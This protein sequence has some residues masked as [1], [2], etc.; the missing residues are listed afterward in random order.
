MSDTDDPSTLWFAVGVLKDAAQAILS[1][2]MYDAM[3]IVTREL[4]KVVPCPED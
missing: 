2:T 3:C 1:E 4:E